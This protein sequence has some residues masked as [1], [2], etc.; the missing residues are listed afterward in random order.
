M[1]SGDVV[2]QL[3][4]QMAR[5]LDTVLMAED[6]E[7]RRAAKELDRDR[8]LDEQSSLLEAS[9]SGPDTSS[10]RLSE[11]QRAKVVG[12]LRPQLHKAE[13]QLDTEEALLES[14]RES[15]RREEERIDQ[16]VQLVQRREAE[17][18]KMHDRLAGEERLLE[19]VASGQ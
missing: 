4:L 6:L 3:L 9:H 2:Y 1:S 17:L 16:E 10:S 11:E 5:K 15:L 7:L 19:L 13:A 8:A 18:K 12:K 14:Q